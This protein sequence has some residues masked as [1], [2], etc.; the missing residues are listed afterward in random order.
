MGCKK[1]DDLRPQSLQIRKASKEELA[2]RD[3]AYKKAPSPKDA[4]R[5]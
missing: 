3:A 4:S 5:R 1:T 2:K